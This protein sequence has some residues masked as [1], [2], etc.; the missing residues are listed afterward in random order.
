MISPTALIADDEPLLRDS[1]ERSLARAWPQLQI[2][3]QARNGREAVEMFQVHRPDIVFLDVHMPGLNGVEAA[4]QIARQ[5]Q[6]VFV[7][8]YEEYALQAFERGAV[9]YLVKPVEDARLSDTVQRLQERLA[10]QQPLPGSS[11]ALEAVIDEL[12]RRMAR[13]PAG[14]LGGHGAQQSG[15]GS[16]AGSSAFSAMAGGLASDSGPLQWI[17]AS[18]GST[19]KLIPVDEI[20]FLRSDEKYTLVVTADGEALI[21]TPIRELIER[22]DPQRFVQVHRSVVVNLHA[23]SHVTRGPNETADLHLKARPEVLPV[24]RSYLHLFRQM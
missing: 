8:A 22:L 15:L 5:A 23:I 17:R 11:A 3:A 18:V 2:V 24:S 13:P 16:S 14:A 10:A 21:R 9:D 7:T 4:R 20:Q 12:A 6:V 19:L 1:L